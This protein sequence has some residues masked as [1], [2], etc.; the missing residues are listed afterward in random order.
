[1]QLDSPWATRITRN[2]F[3]KSTGSCSFSW[4][5]H[6]C[7]D[8]RGAP[9][10]FIVKFSFIHVY[11]KMWSQ[12]LPFPLWLLL[13]SPQCIVL[14]PTLSVSLF[15]L[16]TTLSSWCCPYVLYC[17]V[18]I[19]AWEP[20]PWP[21]SQIFLYLFPWEQGLTSAA[22]FESPAGDIHPAYVSPAWLPSS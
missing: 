7:H 13:L 21:H 4:L 20:L 16:I 14:F 3:F 15:Y 8:F 18:S 22:D 2:C 12:P 17:G 5:A 19:G 9:F 1:M 10:F 6:D 11:N